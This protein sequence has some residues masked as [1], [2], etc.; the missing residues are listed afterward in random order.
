VGR[1]EIPLQGSG[2]L[3][4]DAFD[5]TANVLI[6]AKGVTTREAMRMAVGQLLDYRRFTPSGPMLAVLLPSY[7]GRDMED[8]AT[9]VGIRLVWRTAAGT[10]TDNAGGSLTG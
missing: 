4:T 7:P 9:S 10:F 8:F 3:Y 1:L 6:E 2:S 5:Q